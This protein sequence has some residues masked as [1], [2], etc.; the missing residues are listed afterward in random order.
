MC[1]FLVGLP[2]I[3]LNQIKFLVLTVTFFLCSTIPCFLFH[4]WSMQ[5]FL[6][7]HNKITNLLKFISLTLTQFL[8]L[9]LYL[10]IRS[11]FWVDKNKVELQ[12]LQ[13]Y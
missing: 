13:L 1:W 7:F 11:K 8:V 4:S 2:A 6:C 5:M 9:V 12:I 3:H 10:Q